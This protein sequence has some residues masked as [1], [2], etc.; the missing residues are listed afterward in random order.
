M[1]IVWVS[2]S[3]GDISMNVKSHE[4]MTNLWAQAQRGY[5]EARK[6]QK[7]PG[8]QPFCLQYIAT[9]STI[10]QPEK[11]DKA[12]RTVGRPTHE[13]QGHNLPARRRSFKA[14]CY[15][16]SSSKFKVT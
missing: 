7:K 9:I 5:R 16:S 8:C 10:M 1:S 15:L 3:N 6:G 13:R 14:I 12:Q 11:L 2:I 4:I